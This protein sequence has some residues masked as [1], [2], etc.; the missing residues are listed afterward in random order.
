MGSVFE[1]R[2]A[3][4]TDMA[5]TESH[6][7][8]GGPHPQLFWPSSKKTMTPAGFLPVNYDIGHI[9]ICAYIEKPFSNNERKAWNE[10]LD[11]FAKGHGETQRQLE[12]VSSLIT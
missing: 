4:A 2:I 5:T 1:T 3:L 12:S 9:P 8:L 10:L 6:H 11:V 7:D